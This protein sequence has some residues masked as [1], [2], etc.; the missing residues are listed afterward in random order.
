VDPPPEQHNGCILKFDQNTPN[1][2]HTTCME[3]EITSIPPVLI[4]FHHFPTHPCR[5]FITSS[6]VPAELLIY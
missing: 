6:P 3:M 5:T 2:L 1:Y 4:Q